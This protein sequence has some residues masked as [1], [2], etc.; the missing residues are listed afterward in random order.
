MISF[1]LSQTKQPTSCF[2]FGVCRDYNVR[3][4]DTTYKPSHAWV[5]L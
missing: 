3:I 4:P 2:V 5:C 1:R